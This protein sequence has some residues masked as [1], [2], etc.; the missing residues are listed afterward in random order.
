MVIMKLKLVKGKA[1]Y[2]VAVAVNVTQPQTT[3]KARKHWDIS[4]PP[5]WEES[6]LRESK[7]NTNIGGGKT[8]GENVQ[9]VWV[10][11]RQERLVFLSLLIM[12]AKKWD[13]KSR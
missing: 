7:K 5:R 3:S 9:V 11:N 2:E 6:S 4:I 8:D 1:A 12:E 13:S 10:E